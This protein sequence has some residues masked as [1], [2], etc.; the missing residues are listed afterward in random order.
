MLVFRVSITSV[1][2]S[3]AVL[4]PFRGM[5]G[6]PMAFR[7][8]AL[9]LPLLPG[10]PLVEFEVDGKSMEVDP[11]DRWLPIAS[12]QDVFLVGAK[13]VNETEAAVVAVM[14]MLESGAD[15]PDLVMIP[16]EVPL[17]SRHDSIVLLPKLAM[18]VSHPL[19]PLPPMA[20]PLL[21][22]RPPRDAA[23]AVRLRVLVTAQKPLARLARLLMWDVLGFDVVTCS[24]ALAR[25]TPFRVPSELVVFLALRLLEH[26]PPLEALQETAAPE[27]LV[28]P[29]MA[30]SV[31]H[32]R[33]LMTREA[34]VRLV[35][36]TTRA[37]SRLIPPRVVE[38][39]PLRL[40][41]LLTRL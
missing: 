5:A 37:L 19:L 12:A 8:I 34:R 9:S 26:R 38:T 22:D 24:R 41:A 20:I 4:A 35:A 23:L 28:P 27:L 11:L 13:L 32:G 2:L 6:L 1:R 7:V 10:A 30:S 33:D 21:P 25:S 40:L 36:M 18:V 3:M 14:C 17:T 39:V 16:P 31:Q 15:A 29:S